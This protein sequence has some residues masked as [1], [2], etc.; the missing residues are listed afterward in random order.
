MRVI[1]YA[2]GFARLGERPMAVAGTEDVALRVRR[3]GVCGTDLGA[4]QRGNPRFRTGIIIGHEL[5]GERMSDGAR[6]T[7]MP[8][9]SCGACTNCGNGAENLCERRVIIGA[10]TDGFLSE[11]V[12]LPA[13]GLIPL[14]DDV[15]DAQA[16]L[17]EP[18]ATALHAWRRAATDRDSRV[19]IIGAGAIGLCIAW[20]ARVKGARCVVAEI[21]GTKHS[22]AA[23]VADE[24]VTELTEV[25]DA[26]FDSVGLATTRLDAIAATRSGGP[27]VFVG[28]HSADMPVDA[29]DLV[30]RERNLLGSFA[31]TVADFE[32]AIGYVRGI[33]TE[34]VTTVSFEDAVDV[35][36]GDTRVPGALKYHVVLN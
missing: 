36:N 30:S 24:V 25:F 18:M 32:D 23:T 33:S 20:V 10:H 16:A 13:T 35:I 22:V 29:N 19:G 21:D 9:I 4:V 27:T 8:L 2:E 3:V 31:Y 15:T 17:I 7:V 1:E 14:P 28:L 34:W 5:V 12:V 11:A 6:F 26:V